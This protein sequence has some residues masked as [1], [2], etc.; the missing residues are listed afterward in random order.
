M[1][2]LIIREVYSVTPVGDMV[3]VDFLQ[4]SENG[5]YRMFKYFDKDEWEEDISKNLVFKKCRS[6][7]KSSTIAK[8]VKVC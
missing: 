1:E 6:F 2:E 5:T 4:V 3:A 7:D 8:E